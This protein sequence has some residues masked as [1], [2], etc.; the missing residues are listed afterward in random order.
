MN[1]PLEKKTTD[2]EWTKCEFSEL[3]NNDIFRFIDNEKDAFVEYRTTSNV[4]PYRN[5][6]AINIEPV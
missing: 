6:L 4:Y 3:K 1:R 5:T 2:N